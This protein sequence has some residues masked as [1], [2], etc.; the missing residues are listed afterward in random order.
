MSFEN[1]SFN[2]MVCSLSKEL[3]DDV[4]D[5]FAAHAGGKIDDVGP[6]PVM[7]WVSGRHLLEGTIDEETCICGGHLYMNLRK[8]ERKVP[9]QL[10]NAICKRDE[11]VYMQ[12]NDCLYVPKKQRMQIKKEA[13]ER[14]LPKMTPIISAI[15]FVID[16]KANML[17]L[18]ANSDAKFDT[19]LAE[20]TSSLGNEYEPVPMSPDELMFQLYGQNANILPTFNLTGNVAA[21]D[22]PMPARDF[23]T[24]MWYDIEMKGGVV[25]HPQFGE[26]TFAME[27]PLT[28]AFSP[29]KTKDPDLTD[30]G[31]T[32]I[33]KGNPMLSG[34]AI[35]ALQS[36]KKMKKAKIL[37]AR[38]NAEKWS[39]SF[40][41]DTFTFNSLT[42]PEG[43]EQERNAKFEER[44]FN[45]FILHSVME[46]YFKKF[47]ESLLNGKNM[48]TEKKLQ[49]W[50][51]QK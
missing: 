8:T 37:M 16:R 46:L 6:E 25:T 12:A 21:K 7:G 40:D 48:E 43:E 23:L 33:K 32:A 41:A 22:E 36:G 31:E 28:F 18:G 30:S 20:Y 34:E 13:V 35:T 5:L 50:A 17:Y 44:I 39:F 47:A 29:T 15:P 4:L 49:E 1:G 38:G 45:L 11:L 24:W 10:L 26:F 19:F 51:K 2:V 14:L 3:P 27:G 42:L 9:S